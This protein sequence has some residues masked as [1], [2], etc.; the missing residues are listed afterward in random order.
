MKTRL[1]ASLLV[2]LTALTARAQNHDFRLAQV[3]T[4]FDFDANGT[5]DR[6]S[7]STYTYDGRNP[8]RS[9]SETDANGDGIV[10][11]RSSVTF[12]Y[13]HRGDRILSVAETYSVAD[14]TVTSRSTITDTYD[15]RG[16][17][18]GELIQFDRPDRK[19]VV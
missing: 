14:N 18:V 3:V 12:T 7:T 16:R 13:N 15:R 8:I 6:V 4:E 2:L 9:V 5:A 10:D 11:S 1:S 19:S 17:R